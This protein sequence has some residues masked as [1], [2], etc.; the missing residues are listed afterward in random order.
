MF[1]TAQPLYFATDYIDLIIIDKTFSVLQIKNY[2]F[3]LK[4]ICEICVICGK[5]NYIAA[6]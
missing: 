1:V 2:L 3:F 6:E 4:L 5:V